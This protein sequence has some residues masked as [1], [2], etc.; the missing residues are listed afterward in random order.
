M[1]C[2]NIKECR[3]TQRRFSDSAASKLR[4]KDKTE[5]DRRKVLT[6]LN[7]LMHACWEIVW[8]PLKILKM[9]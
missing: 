2:G 9:G 7:T 6:Y 3:L 5:I 8:Q 1:M 4:P